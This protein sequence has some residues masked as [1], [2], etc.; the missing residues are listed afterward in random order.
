[1][2]A[3]DHGRTDAVQTR[4]DFR[5]D[6]TWRRSLGRGIFAVTVIAIAYLTLMP[7]YGR[8]R[9]RI[10]PIPLYR[11][12]AAPEQDWFVNVVAFGFLAVVVFIAGE[13]SPPLAARA[14]P[15]EFLRAVAHASPRCSR[16][17][18]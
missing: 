14:N 5:E 11:W 15:S 2:I 6:R 1:V 9:F 13:N 3:P 7:N 18:A 16:S 8:T 4:E 10:V 12:L 17:C